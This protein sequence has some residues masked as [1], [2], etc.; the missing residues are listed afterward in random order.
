[1]HMIIRI[2]CSEMDLLKA[3]SGTFS[4]DL[5]ENALYW[6]CFFLNVHETG[7]LRRFSNLRHFSISLSR[8]F[9]YNTEKFQRVLHRRVNF[10]FQ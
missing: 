1:M 4:R 10:F 9:D 2:S 6:Q 3:F 8:R 7:I 5:S